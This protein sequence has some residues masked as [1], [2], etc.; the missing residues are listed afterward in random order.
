M[1]TPGPILALDSSTT[2][3]SVAVGGAD[4]ELLAEV[5]LN[6]AGAHSAA[7]LPAA[8]QALR[9]AGLATRDLAAVVVGAGPG[10]FTGLRIAAATAK[11]IVQALGLP[12]LAYPSLLAAAVGG[13]AAGEVVALFDA[14][15]RDV[16][17]AHYR[18][19]A[20]EPAVT[21][22]EPTALSLDEVLERFAGGAP[23][24]FVGDG[25]WAHRDELREALGARVLAPELGLP[26]AS[27]LLWLARTMP[28]AGRVDDA[29]AWEPDY[30][31]AAGAERI[32][33]AGGAGGG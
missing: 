26:R 28:A 32:A 14:R 27:H 20:G 21:L 3:G 23:P 16:Y 10:S 19:A 24:L 31:R 4:G 13:L 17:A 6:V 8:D 18:F 2:T 5:V 15:R 11:G 29:A 9:S 33:A 7:L 12:L 1:P 25:A 22:L 30:V